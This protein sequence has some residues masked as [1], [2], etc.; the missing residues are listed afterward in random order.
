MSR[1]HP[2]LFLLLNPGHFLWF[3]QAYPPLPSSSAHTI[4]AHLVDIC[5]SDFCHVQGT[6]NRCVCVCLAVVYAPMK[7]AMLRVIRGAVFVKRCICSRLAH[8]SS[9]LLHLVELSTSATQRS[10]PYAC[11]S[12][13]PGSTCNLIT[14]KSAA[15]KRTEVLG[16]QK[17]V[18]RSLQSRHETFKKAAVSKYLLCLSSITSNKVSTADVKARG[19]F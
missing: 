3:T 9:D 2:L 17:N 7:A 15:D 1:W 16:L 13:W 6:V 10:F 8:A 18:G 4:S 12:I 5:P 19:M 11:L 14:S